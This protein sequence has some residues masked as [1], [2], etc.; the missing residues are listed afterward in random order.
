MSRQ[1]RRKMNKKIDYQIEK[2][3]LKKNIY[4]VNK[5]RYNREQTKLLDC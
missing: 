3:E 2:S 4:T 1:S 5:K